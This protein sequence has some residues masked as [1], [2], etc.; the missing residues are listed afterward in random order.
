MKAL[1]LILFC[2]SLTSCM[3]TPENSRESL[4]NDFSI[5]GDETNLQLKEDDLVSIS[6]DGDE[7]D[8]TLRAINS[9]E[10][11][12]FFWSTGIVE[13]D[14]PHEVVIPQ[15]M[16]VTKGLI[17]ELTSFYLVLDELYCKYVVVGQGKD[18]ELDNCFFSN[19]DTETFFTGIKYIA[20]EKV[21]LVINEE[22][23]EPGIIYVEANLS[24]MKV[25]G[26]GPPSSLEDP[27]VENVP[28]VD[29]GDIEDDIEQREDYNQDLDDVAT[30]DLPSCLMSLSAYE[31]LA[32]LIAGHFPLCKKGQGQYSSDETQDTCDNFEK[33]IKG[34]DD[35]CGL[36]L[37]AK[38]T[39]DLIMEKCHRRKKFKRRFRFRRRNKC[40]GKRLSRRSGKRR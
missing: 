16:A 15:T 32:L 36:A 25:V 10:E 5:A 33:D 9:Q 18:L 28:D 17:K 29:L 40:K 26:E 6:L 2:G 23:E 13:L 19:G 12:E 37:L 34:S 7:F 39:V 38:V 27:G 8:I 31:K 22:T 35:R 30:S 20:E 24:A 4:V 14:S 21:L 11:G 3:P 1:I